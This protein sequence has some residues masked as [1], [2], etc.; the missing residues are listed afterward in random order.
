MKDELNSISLAHFGVWT[1]DD[2]IDLIN[3][4]EDFHNEAKKYIIKWYNENPSAEY[5]AEKYHEKFIPSSKIHTK[6]NIHGLTLETQWFID[7]LK[8]SGDLA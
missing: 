1:D 6:E 7:G 8:N 5:V 4:V 2:F 3:Q